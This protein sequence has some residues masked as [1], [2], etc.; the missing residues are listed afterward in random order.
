MF[1]G[2]RFGPC[3]AH[4][5][6]SGSARIGGPNISVGIG[7]G[8]VAW[9]AGGWTRPMLFFVLTRLSQRGCLAG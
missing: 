7:A 3:P 9:I 8:P 1:E 2:I 6:S 5:R 4:G